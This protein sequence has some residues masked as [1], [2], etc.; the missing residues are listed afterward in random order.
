MTRAPVVPVGLWGTDEVWP[1]S[2]RLPR[3]D[4]RR[5]VITVTVGPPVALTYEDPDD[6]T[7]RIMAAIVELLPPEA[8]ERRIPT[9][10]R[11]GPHLPARLPG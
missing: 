7:R 11:A 4:G 2:S 6:D 9:E 1:R 8:R 3:F 5:P 10:E